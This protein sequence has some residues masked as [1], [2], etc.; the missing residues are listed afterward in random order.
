VGWREG[1]DDRIG[2]ALDMQLK[3]IT[4]SVLGALALLA[5]ALTAVSP[6]SAA[7]ID[8]VCIDSVMGDNSDL[9]V[10][11]TA[12][13]PGGPVAAGAEVSLESIDQSAEISPD[14]FVIGYSRGLLEVGE[15]QIPTSVR[16]QIEA[17]NT[18]EGTQ[19]TNEVASQI[20]TTITDPTPEDAMSGD[21]SATPGQLDAAFDDQTWTAGGGP[22]ADAGPDQTVDTKANVA[23]DGTG[24]SAFP[25][26][27]IDFRE[28]T[29]T[30]LDPGDPGAGGIVIRAEFF[31]G[32]FAAYFACSPGMVVG[33]DAQF[34]DPSTPFA[35]TD[36]ASGDPI[37]SY[38]WTQTSGPAVNLSGA[39]TPTPSFTAPDQPANLGFELE[40]DDG[41]TTDTDGVAVSAGAESGENSQACQTAKKKVKRAK[42]KVKKAK[43]KVKKAKKRGTKARKRAKKKVKKAKKKLKKAKK[44]KRR[45]C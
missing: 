27:T 10:D 33:G 40:V 26:G 9:P 4:G 43:K 3:G 6:A 11:I 39:N 36:V 23:L 30:N 18:V 22:T 20:E 41:A 45:N 38:S 34:D 21:E 7:T 19:E 1:V 2:S 44:Q 5:A 24:S 32:L 42:K 29:V 16:T 31:G 13:A 28:K 14:V 35:S 15:N 37:S 17:T 8:N 25:G 12:I